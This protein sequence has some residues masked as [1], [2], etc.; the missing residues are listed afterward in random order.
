MALDD[1]ARSLIRNGLMQNDLDADF[2]KI[3]NLDLTGFPSIPPDSFPPTE[4]FFINSYDA[5]THEFTSAQPVITGIAGFPDQTGHANEFLKT[6][7]LGTLSWSPTPGGG[8]GGGGNTTYINVK[9]DP[10]NAAGDGVTNDH[11]AIAQAIADAAGG[12]VYFPKGIYYLGSNLAPTGPVTLIGD[13]PLTSILKANPAIGGAILLLQSGSWVQRMGFLG[14]SES[15]S[16]PGPLNR[17]GIGTVNSLNIMIRDCAVVNCSNSGILVLTSIST[18]I[19]SCAVTDC[20]VNGIWVV[21][22]PRTTIGDTQVANCGQTGIFVVNSQQSILRHNMVS[23]AFN[24]GILCADSDNTIVEG[25]IVQ[26][27][28]IGILISVSPLRPQPQVSYGY[29]VSSNNIIRNYYG[30]AILGLTNGIRFTSNNV[31]ENGA[32]VGSDTFTIERGATVDETRPDTGYQV[33]DILTVSGGTGTAAKLLV[34]KMD[35]ANPDNIAWDGLMVL[36]YGNYTVF[37]SNPMSVTGGT[38]SGAKVVLSLARISAGGTGYTVGQCLRATNGDFNNP[39]RVVVTAVTV[40]TGA[41]IGAGLLDGGGYT[42]TL[43]SVLTFASEATSPSDPGDSLDTGD[44]GSGFQ[45]QPCW[46]NRYAQYQGSNP[47]GV[48]TLGGLA[49]GVL[50]NNVIDST[51]NGIGIL[52][53]RL[54]DPAGYSGF[55]QLLCVTGNNVLNADPATFSIKAQLDN[56]P[57]DNDYNH[58]G[59]SIFANN[60]LYP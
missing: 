15:L 12:T 47:F 20:G 10:Y 55:A 14:S 36:S 3:L 1:G 35:P 28:A 29:S 50:G 45:I 59:N 4:N 43:P 49:S 6:N 5:D 13:S 21:N 33:G 53:R 9:S 51:R 44:S 41:I 58:F 60:I 8:G 42:G 27:N 7:G 54:S 23:N 24:Y 11:D 30:G 16:Q 26:E 37:P 46:G 31:L 2:H 40:A 38:G 56:D 22:S 25:N 52:V 32:G 17:V 48:Q 19:H 57:P 34:T 18:Q 39:V